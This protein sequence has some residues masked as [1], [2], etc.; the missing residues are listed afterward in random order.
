MCARV[1]PPHTTSYMEIETTCSLS[2]GWKVV[3][4]LILAGF[5]LILMTTQTLLHSSILFQTLL[6]FK[7][8][9]W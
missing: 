8:H 4:L 1:P 9:N 7:Y 3:F 2:L 5:F 6:F